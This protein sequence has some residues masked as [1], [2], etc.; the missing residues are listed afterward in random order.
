MPNA[1]LTSRAGATWQVRPNFRRCRTARRGPHHP[2]PLPA[3]LAPL[4]DAPLRP[5]RPLGARIHGDV[6]GLLPQ[7][8]RRGHPWAPL[9]L[10][11][12]SAHLP[13]PRPADGRAQ[14]GLSGRK[15]PHIATP[16]HGILSRGLTACALRGRGAGEHLCDPNARSWLEA[17]PP[18]WRISPSPSPSP[19][20]PCR[21]GDD[22]LDPL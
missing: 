12:V 20:P 21:A 3:R 8:A 15:G 11:L 9:P 10:P 1:L 13:L 22:L 14:R 2:K 7:R 4:G 5:L 19:Y 16:S 18:L 6:I 17:S